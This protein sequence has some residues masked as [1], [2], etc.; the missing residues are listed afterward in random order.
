M[1]NSW[2]TLRLL[3]LTQR[4]P[5][6]TPYHRSHGQSS[7]S[8]RMC[9]PNRRRIPYRVWAFA[10]PAIIA[11]KCEAQILCKQYIYYSVP[12][13]SSN[14]VAC[15]P[16]TGLIQLGHDRMARPLG[17]CLYRKIVYCAWRSLRA[18]CAREWIARSENQGLK[19]ADFT[20]YFKALSDKDK[21]VRCVELG[22]DTAKVA[23]YL[24][25]TSLIK[26][27]RKMR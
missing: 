17:T 12:L 27:W 1:E 5:D 25:C 24:C 9:R 21:Q 16:K 18:F 3:L 15:N 11:I 22:L 6:A 8:V 14:P 7:L 10:D 4:R 26:K 23:N 13:T 20:A 19:R 2:T